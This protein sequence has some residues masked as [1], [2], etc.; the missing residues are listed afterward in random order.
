MSNLIK[1]L[2][3]KIANIF[4]VP[5]WLIYRFKSK[6]LGSTGA[7]TDVSQLSS[8]WIGVWGVYLRASLLKHIIK[9][10]GKNLHVCYGT[11]MTKPSIELGDDVYIGNYCMIGDCK[12]G[13]NTLIADHVMIPSGNS[14]HGI[15]R[16]DIPITQQQGVYKKI[17][18]G[19][20]CW[21]G[22]GSVILA[23]VGSHC[24]VGAGSVVTKPVD[25]FLIVAGNPAKMISDRQLLVGNDE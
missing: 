17:L 22:S 3:E 6:L 21:I 20:D 24:V 25:D 1:I 16:L 11:I 8:R 14:Q 12:I 7:F 19:E 2:A 5:I 10:T 9:Y 15:T 18:I 13:N 4:A 23:D